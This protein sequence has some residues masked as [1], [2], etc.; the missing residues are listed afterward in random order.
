M[1][2]PETKYVR[3]GDV[4]IA[5]QIVGDGPVDLVYVPG[6]C[7]VVGE[8][9]SGIAVHVGARVASLASAGEVLVSTTVKDLVAGSGIRFESRGAHALKGIPDEWPLFTVIPESAL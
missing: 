3:S 9:L 7:E 4:S 1:L 8:K 2:T 5:Y 6:E